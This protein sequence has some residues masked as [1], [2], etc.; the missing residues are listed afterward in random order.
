MMSFQKKRLR[1]SQHIEIKK[2]LGDDLTAYLYILKN[3]Y[4][5]NVVVHIT[6]RNTCKE[7]RNKNTDNI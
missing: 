5:L 2:D 7:F 3:A 6:L 4:M 1:Y